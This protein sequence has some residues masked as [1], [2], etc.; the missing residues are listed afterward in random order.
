MVVNGVSTKT[1]TQAIQDAINSNESVF[2]G[3]KG[4][5]AVI[6]GATA[7]TGLAGTSAAV[8]LGGTDLDRTFAFTIP[9]GDKGESGTITSAT[10][11]TGAEGTEASVTLGGTSSSRTFAFTILKGIQVLRATQ[12]HQL[13]LLLLV[14]LQVQ[15]AL[16]QQL[17]L[18]VQTQLE[19]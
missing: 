19:L 2:K 12:A 6:S 10:A 9:R 13:L 5:S 15:Q 7:T 14:L 11:S 8:S 16:K 18:V 1:V 17:R 3:E 4:D